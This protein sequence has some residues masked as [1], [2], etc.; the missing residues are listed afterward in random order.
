VLRRLGIVIATLALAACSAA[1]PTAT[2]LG[3]ARADWTSHHTG[4]GYTDVLADANDRVAGFTVT[5]SPRTLAD[6][7]ALVRRDLPADT[8]SSAASAAEGVEGTKCLIVDFTSSTLQKSLGS[9][10]AMVVFSTAAAVMM[11]TTKI[12]HA[13]VVSASENYPRAC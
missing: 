12:D 6:A 7:E 4:G 11:D 2:G 8:T 9:D 1:T 13:V 10:R 3:A 5:M